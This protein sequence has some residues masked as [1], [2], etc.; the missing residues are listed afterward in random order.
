MA[1]SEHSRSTATDS[2]QEDRSR[3]IK[4]RRV[5]QAAGT[6]ALGAGA[7]TGAASAQ[8]FQRVV[9]CGCGRVCASGDGTAQV[10]VAQPGPGGEFETEVFERE[11]D[12]CASTDECLP[13][14]G[15][16]IAVRDAEAEVLICN[17]NNCA[18]RALNTG[19]ECEDGFGTSGGPCNEPP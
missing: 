12:F 7:F 5:L 10:I 1:P 6:T 15:Q 2:R 14:G 11:F 8:E 17:P 9:F 3:H 4:R 16:I 19:Y 18:K 13:R